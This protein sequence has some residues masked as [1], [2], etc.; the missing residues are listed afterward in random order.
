MMCPLITLTNVFSQRKCRLIPSYRTH[1]ITNSKKINVGSSEKKIN[2][3]S[4]EKK[5]E[6]QAHAVI[7]DTSYNK[8]YRELIAL[9]RIF[10]FQAR[11]CAAGMTVH[12]SMPCAIRCIHKRTISTKRT[13]S[14]DAHL[15]S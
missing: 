11:S 14:I 7:Q 3:G 15:V 8:F 12:F 2:V 5:N 9:T 4:S 13:H 6:M 10:F 1:H